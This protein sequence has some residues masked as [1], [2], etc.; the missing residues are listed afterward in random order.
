MY[1]INLHFTD[2]FKKKKCKFVERIKSNE[3]MD[4]Y[5]IV[6]A[7]GNYKAEKTYMCHK[8]L[9]IEL[10]KHFTLHMIPYTET[11]QIPS[12][13]YKLVFIADG[14]VADIA[15]ANFSSFPYPITLLTDGLENSLSAA[16]EIATWVRSKDMLVKII[17]SRPTEMVKQVLSHYHAFIGKRN[18]K[19]KR[20]GVIGTPAP[21]L[22]SS[23][24]DYLLASR[25]WGVS[26][27]DIPMEAVYNHF[28]TITDD[29][30]GLEASL[31]ATRAQAC[32]DAAPE[33]LLRD[34]RL[35]KAIRRVCEEEQLDAL[36]LSSF[37]LMQDLSTNGNL[38]V[39]LLND[40]GIPAGN[41]GDLQAIMTLLMV[42]ELTGQ[43]GFI[44]NLAFV[45]TDKNEIIL[46]HDTISTKMTDSFILR[47][48]NDVPGSMAIQGILHE[49]EITLFKC[50]SE[51]LDEYYIS[52]GY[53]AEN[54]NMVS[55]CRTQLRIKIDK[56][57][58]YFLRNPLGNHHILIKGNH[59]SMIQEFM[60]QNRCKLRE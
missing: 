55:N 45:D 27:I 50:G 56:P 54:T 44:A 59:C 12:N 17:H 31:L 28:N 42:H 16:L 9:F 35:Y 5:L 13:A 47:D 60:Q 32:Q 19:G 21:W 41:E 25:R 20:I 36:T 26:Y 49:E 37:S 23:H 38:A 15:I 11:E 7:S 39:A 57:A 34:M 51:C 43:P 52:S 48:Q 18:L 2:E 58:T 14:C 1:V 30:I 33:D 8:D 3:L 53:L 24:A 40:E 6:F 29:E 10:E 4:L 22:I 46:A